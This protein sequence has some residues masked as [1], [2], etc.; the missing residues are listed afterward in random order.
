VALSLDL[1]GGLPAVPVDGERLQQVLFNLIA[2]AL[3]AT[4]EGGRVTVTAR[5]DPADAR[6]RLAVSDTGRGISAADLSRLF[7]P[8]FT[9]RPEGTGLGL[10]VADQIVRESGGRMAV[11]SAVGV[12]STFTVDLPHEE[13]R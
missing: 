12:G 9:T 1:A 7:E 13:K 8:F 6:V 11:D 3:E 2:N 5:C 4:P 10:A